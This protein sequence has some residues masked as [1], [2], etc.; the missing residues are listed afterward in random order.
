MIEERAPGSFIEA[1]LGLWDCAGKRGEKP[2]A[3]LHA[4]AW[5]PS[6]RNETEFRALAG[7]TDGRF[8]RMT[9]ILALSLALASAISVAGCATQQQTNT[10]G[11]AA[12]GGAGGALIGSALSHGS[13]GGAIAGGV[14]GAATGAMIGNAATPPPPRRCAQWAYDVNGNRVCTAFF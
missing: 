3:P 1:S 4:P 14:I 10:L 13:P 11:G 8:D 12:I 5:L 7:E 6:R 2:L 9:R